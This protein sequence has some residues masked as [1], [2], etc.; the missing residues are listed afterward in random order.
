MKS[1]FNRSS[2]RRDDRPRRQRQNWKHKL[3]AGESLEARA[4]LAIDSFVYPA[5]L[6]NL[7]PDVNHDGIISALDALIVINDI[8]A[9]GIHATNQSAA[10]SGL[11]ANS[12]ASSSQTTSLTGAAFSLDVNGDGMVTPLD[13][14]LITNVL[15]TPGP[16]IIAQ[17]VAIDGSGNVISTS[18]ST[19]NSLIINNGQDFNLVLRVTDVRAVADAG[20]NFGV[21]TA[22]TDISITN[23]SLATLGTVVQHG[24]DYPNGALGTISSSFIDAAGGVSASLSHLDKAAHTL[25]QT[26]VHTTSVGTVTYTPD[27]DRVVNGNS[28]SGIV[29]GHEFLLYGENAAVVDPTQVLFKPLTVTIGG[30]ATSQPTVSLVGNVTHPEGNVGDSTDFVFAVQLSSSPQ[31]PVN[32]YVTTQGGTA[33]AGSDYT[34][35]TQTLTFA[36]NT[37]TLTQNVTVSVIG[38]NIVEPDETFNVTLANPVN[39]SLGTALRTGTIVN[40]DGIG[41]VLAT[42]TAPA[43]TNEGNSGTTHFV[44]T[45]NLSAAPTSTATVGFQTVDGTATVLNN[46]Y[47]ATSGTLTFTAGQTSTTVTVNV[48]GDTVLEANETFSLQLSA[49]TGTALGS[50]SSATATILNDDSAAPLVTISADGSNP[51]MEDALPAQRVFNVNLS[52]PATQVSTVTFSTVDG[53][54]IAGGNAAIGGQD[55]VA[56]SGTLTFTVGQSSAT[57]TVAVN[58]DTVN[59]ANE[60]FSVQL[61]S[62]AGV[63]LGSTT[64]AAALLVN[65]DPFPALSIGN[66]SVAEGN[67][68]QTDATF[69]VTQSAVSGQTVLVSFTT[70]DGTAAVADSDYVAQSGTLTF[71]PGDTTKNIIVK[72]NGDTKY[73]A[74][75]TYSVVLSNAVNAT[76]SGTTGQGTITNDD[77]P[78]TISITPATSAPEGNSGITQVPV[79]VVLSAASGLTTTVVVTSTD[80]TAHAPTDY[81]AISQTLTF[82]PG[83]TAQVVTVGIVGN[84]L[85]EANKAFSI[86]LSAPTNATLSAQT[87]NAFTIVND[88]FRAQVSINNVSQAEGNAGITNFVFTVSLSNAPGLS[89]AVPYTTANGDAPG[90]AQAGVDYN[91]VSGNLT[92]GPAETSKTITVQVIGNTIIEPAKHF[93]VLLGTLPTDF[94]YQNG[95]NIGLGTIQDDDG[96]PLI[97]INDVSKLEGNSGV[98]NF[99]FEVDLSRALTSSVLVGYATADLGGSASATAG[100]DYQAVSSQLTF[101]AGATQQFITVPVFGNTTLQNDRTFLV[102]LSNVIDSGATGTQISGGQAKGTI[103]DDDQPGLTI[104]GTGVVEGNAGTTPAVFQVMLGAAVSNTVTVAY[105]TQDGTATLANNDY[106]ATSGVLTFFP[107]DTLKTITVLVKGDTTIE[108]DEN[109]KVNLSSSTGAAILTSSATGTIFNDD[110]TTTKSARFRLVATDTSGNPLTTVNVGQDFQL[111]AFVTDLSTPIAHGVFSAYADIV[112]DNS[113]VFHY[114]AAPGVSYGSNYPN[115]HTGDFSS[116]SVFKSVGATS[117]ASELGASE[118]LLFVIPLHADSIGSLDFSA[119]PPTNGFETTLYASNTPVSPPFIDFVSASVQVGTNFF[120]VSST[121]QTEGNSGVTPVVFTVTRNLPGATPGTATVVASLADFTATLADADYQSRITVNGT[122][123][124]SGTATLTFAPGTTTQQVTAYI[125][126]DTKFE[127][128]EAFRLNLSSPVNASLGQSIGTAVITNDDAPPSVSIQPATSTPEGDSGT[129]PVTLNLILSSVSGAATTVVVNTQNGTAIAGT[130]YT[131]LVNQTVTIA[132]GQTT[133]PVTI[134]VIGNTLFEP[135]KSFTVNLSSPTNATLGATTSGTVTITNDDPRALVAINDVTQLEGNS[136]T[137]DFVFTV[138]LVNSAGTPTA[139]GVTRTI[140]FNTANGDTPI[141]GIAGQDYIATSGTL[142]FGPTDTS[143]TITVPVIGNLTI[144]STKHFKVNLSGLAAD[145]TFQN[146]KSTGIGSILDDDGSPQIS[147]L[148]VSMP[149]GNSGFT[150]FVFEIDLNRQLDHNVSVG[151]ATT[152]LGGAASATAGV[153][154]IATSGRVTFAPGEIVKFV[155]VSVVG[156]TQQEPNETFLMNLSAVQEVGVNPPTVSIAGG[157]AQGVIVDDDSPGLSITSTSVLEGNSG[158]T[159]AIFTVSLTQTLTQTVTVAFATADGTATTA[160]NDYIATTGVLTFAAGETSKNITVPVIGNTI[161]EPDKTFAVNLSNSVGAPINVGVGTGTIVNDDPTAAQ[162]VQLHLLVTN[163]SGTPLTAVDVGQNF[164]LNVYVKDLRSVNA[165]GVFSAY[166]NIANDNPSTFHVNPSGL[167]FGANYPNVH[168][169][170]LSNNALYTG[171][172]A[173]SNGT[174]LGNSEQLLF[175]ISLHADAAGKLDFSSLPSTNGFETLLLGDNSAVANAFINFGTATLQVGTNFFSIDN[176]SHSEGN[177]G[178]TPYVFTVTRNFPPASPGTATVLATIA[179]S[180]ATNASGD[181]LKKITINGVDFASGAATL[182]FAPGTTTQQVTAYVNGDTLNEADET[183]TL[184]L[185]SASNASIGSGTGLGTIVN[186][187]AAPTLTIADAS[188]LEGNNAVFTLTL[189]TTSGQDI[190]VVFQT[191]AFVGSNPATAGADYTAASGTVTI[192]AGQTTAQITVATLQDLITEPTEHFVVNISSPIATV[193]RNSAVGNILDARPLQI[194]GFVYVDANNDGVKQTSEV[195]IPGVKVTAIPHTSAPSVTVTTD[196]NGAY[197]FVLTPGTYD[198]VET[199]PG[200]FVDG[201]ETV[202][203]YDAGVGTPTPVTG[204]T[205]LNDRF[206]GVAISTLPAVGFNF[207]E[208]GV[209]P[210]FVGSFL[211]RHALIASEAGN[212][213]TPLTT[214]QVDPTAD[215]H[216]NVSSATQYVAFDGGWTGTRGFQLVF[217]TDRGTAKLQILDS[218][219]K[220][221]AQTDSANPTAPIFFTPVA[222]VSYFVAISG[223]NPDVT[224]RMRETVSIDD[225]TVLE[226]VATTTGGTATTNAVFTVHLSNPVN[227]TTT[228]GYSTADNTAKSS[229]TAVTVGS[230]TVTFGP[231][232]TATNG[233]LTLTAGQ[234]TATITV[235]VLGDAVNTPDL[236]FLVNL[237]AVNNLFIADHQAVGTILNNDPP[238]AVRVSDAAVL[239][240]NAGTTASLVFT[241]TLTAPTTRTVTA[242]FASQDITAVAGLDYYAT[243]GS[244]TFLPGETS[245]TVTVTVIGDNRFEPNDTLLLKLSNL[246]NAIFGNA[247]GTGT[248]INDDPDPNAFITAN[249]LVISKTDSWLLDLITG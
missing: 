226:P 192:P 236:N 169:G 159:N 180:T 83:Q 5:G 241:V 168:T 111:R 118:Q 31:L 175:T 9:N 242:Q 156:D 101:T 42:V 167:T 162:S 233:T 193:V 10:K 174:A 179:D 44:F 248:I 249:D 173:T 198:I 124:A 59:E 211:N 225:V 143:E 63:S 215:P 16:S 182:T 86:N 53:T 158:T 105:S 203:V 194:S 62:A 17:L 84:T 142:T 109:F 35:L 50:P 14:L 27:F 243:S 160:H 108:P 20:G 116:T 144:E 113:S 76:L 56:K 94:G 165:Q 7:V 200:F 213:G 41:Q 172:G 23:S 191:G 99:V 47:V 224:L 110:P 21:F 122:D 148:G 245:K 15:N 2:M 195:G 178:V 72:I 12:L 67:S 189:N 100:V 13:A 85:F 131:A 46:D 199:Q 155:T 164:L 186:D 145:L 220:V 39:A 187:D 234:T 112:N 240:G 90:V 147:I 152:D 230:G 93:K 177:S 139:T 119:I 214:L 4:L 170:N 8:N 206:N 75:E 115:V 11:T 28:G 181:Y 231:N 130:D 1:F 244:I 33:T 190:P 70:Q 207:G 229:S 135:D 166:M 176:V 197:A 81:Q 37:A 68:G 61:T 202:G 221:L 69:V 48:V 114:L 40:D 161:V 25:W 157:Q 219:L 228:V 104:A 6:A 22:Y 141:V 223:T 78:P 87:S 71:A 54:A 29:A 188:A 123:F 58:P 239:E 210:E 107:G 208:Q 121:S 138:S 97:T 184:K 52:S 38:D 153:D 150:P 146:G 205:V 183:F 216:F 204:V 212:N 49:G 57:I 126:G 96:P 79:S 95:N 171:V 238:A 106:T 246:T 34:S 60:S 134:N 18:G 140:A 73:E 32:V 136:G 43:A 3:H 64:S 89:L 117:G 51:T 82:A 45:V 132:A 30:A 237:F 201:K 218:K 127:A 247:S 24:S 154:Y 74:N 163:T 125:V 232:Y 36:A 196:S 227:Q 128:D 91:A 92:F 55:Y 149:E 80:G 185:T 102:N 19:Q 77:L 129:H 217:D 222:G 26:S 151:F 209:R 137:T 88:D 98:T 120:S 235:P 66:R 103:I 133:A 65:D